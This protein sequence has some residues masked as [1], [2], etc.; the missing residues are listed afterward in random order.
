[1]QDFLLI[2]W[3]KETIFCFEKLGENGKSIFRKLYSPSNKSSIFKKMAD[4]VEKIMCCI[5]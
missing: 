1:M 3:S 2:I 4:F 5:F